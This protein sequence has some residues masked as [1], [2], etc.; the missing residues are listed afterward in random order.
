MILGDIE[1]LE[2][3]VTLFGGEKLVLHK[4]Q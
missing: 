1:V 2:V 3:V 4:Q